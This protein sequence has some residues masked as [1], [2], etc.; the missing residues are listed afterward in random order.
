[1]GSKV[2][3]LLVAGM[4]LTFRTEQFSHASKIPGQAENQTS[5]GRLEAVFIEY[6]PYEPNF[7]VTGNPRMGEYI[8]LC[9]QNTNVEKAI[10]CH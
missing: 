6:K 9:C 2:F 5:P 4:D 8:L 10:L 3:E 7:T 1:M